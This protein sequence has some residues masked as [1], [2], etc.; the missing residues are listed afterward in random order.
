VVVTMT[1]AGEL[2]GQI[3]TSTMFSSGVMYSASATGAGGVPSTPSTATGSSYVVLSN[4]NSVGLMFGGFKG[5]SVELVPSPG[6][7]M[8]LYTIVLMLD[9]RTVRDA[10]YQASLV[11]RRLTST[12]RRVV[13]RRQACW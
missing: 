4:D 10:V 8:Q 13:R 12:V 6:L 7:G 1:I 3:V 2:R 11:R 5:E 9:W